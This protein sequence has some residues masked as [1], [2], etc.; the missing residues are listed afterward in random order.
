[1]KIQK[2]IGNINCRFTGMNITLMED[3]DTVID[4]INISK[5]RL[6][7]KELIKDEVL[8]KSLKN[9]ERKDKLLYMKELRRV[10]GIN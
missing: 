10:F 6:M 3:N 8:K 4:T 9:L 2:L 1:M 7:S 5:D